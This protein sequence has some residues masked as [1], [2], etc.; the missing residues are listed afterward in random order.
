MAEMDDG[1]PEQTKRIN[2]WHEAY[3]DWQAQQKQDEDQR[4]REIVE[5]LRIARACGVPDEYLSV[6]E[7]ET[8]VTIQ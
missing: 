8:G 5:A 6:L 7:R 2:Q 1:S 3:M 4:Y